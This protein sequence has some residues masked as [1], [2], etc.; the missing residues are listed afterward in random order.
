MS[1]LSERP[2]AA[3]PPVTVPPSGPSL[4]L[5]SALA[6]GGALIAALYLARDV[7][8]PL[9]L[10]ILISFTLA[11]LVNRLRRIGL[12]RAPS[13]MIVVTLALGLV[14]GFFWLLVGQAVHLAGDLP[15][16]EDNLREKIR[17]LGPD[18][19]GSGVFE[20][21]ADLLRRVGREFDKVTTPEG[22]PPAQALPAQTPRPIPVEVHDPPTSPL[23]ALLELAGVIAA[24]LAT[25]GIM[26]LFIVYVLLQREDLRD[27]F[28]RLFGS[29]DVH[30]T[31]QA[32]NDAGARIGRYLLM[33]LTVNAV[34]GTLFGVALYLIGVPNALLWGL[35][36]VVLRFIPFIGAPLSLL[37]PLILSLAV[38]SGWNMP[39]LTIGAFLVIEVGCTYLL[40]PV[41]FGSSTGLSMIALIIAALFWT[42]LWGPVGLL[43][44][45]PLT[46][47]L[48]V[49]GR[50]VPQLEFLEVVLGNRQ[51]LS[52][53]LKLYQRLL[54]DDPEEATDVAE[55]FID[56]HGL[57]RGADEV[58]LPALRLIAQDRVRGVLDRARANA[59]A[60]DLVA[61]AQDVA[62]ESGTA[63]AAPPAAAPVVCLGAGSQLDE[64]AARLAALVLRQEGLPAETFTAERVTQARPGE[65]PSGHPPT[66]HPE[67]VLV[68]AIGPTAANRAGR[69]IRRWR[70]RAGETVPIL[71]GLWP[72]DDALTLAE[73]RERSKADQVAT[74]LDDLI[75]L[76]RVRLAE[77]APQSATAG[78][79]ATGT[80]DL[81]PAAMP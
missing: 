45:A 21:T 12:G 74:S 4:P 63:P 19:A 13:V 25:I 39:L 78:A 31:T 10:A 53:E 38:D 65:L 17:L 55:E 40:E 76:V 52:S 69:F 26:L 28:I 7:F 79:A 14:V 50:H 59:M 61:I 20:Q 8:V 33:Q 35:M 16:Y 41:L 18:A 51:A 72:T 32:M 58:L 67:A 37:F 6:I 56:E 48:V 77:A 43:L 34:Y 24:P 2:E 64:A 47:C 54:A 73:L 70:V 23:G 81:A 80:G 11:P 36:G 1:A 60:E 71:A 9:A 29:G 30:R 22:T 42:M 27:R 3:A 57:L 75:G 46:A 62:S 68:L 66:G 15:R 49:L 5:T 44:A